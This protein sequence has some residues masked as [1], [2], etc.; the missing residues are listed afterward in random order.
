[1]LSDLALEVESLGKCY[2]VF[3]NPRDRL[4]QSLPGQKR[5]FFKAVWALEDVSFQLQ[6]GHTLGVVGRNGSGKSTLLQLICGTLSPTCGRVSVRGR[7]A[8]LLELGSGFNPD[9]SGLENVFLNG[10]LLGLK[11]SEVEDRLD[12]ILSFA[13]IGDYIHQPVKTYSSG[14]GLR[15]A[16]A[17]QAMLDPEILIVDEA[18][19]VGDERFQKKCYSHL[20]KLREQGTSVLLVTHSCPTIVQ[21]CDQAL[22]LHR[23]RARLMGTP[24]VVTTVYQR[25]SGDANA[26]WTE[27]LADLAQR[28][29]QEAQSDSAHSEPADGESESDNAAGISVGEAIYDSNLVPASRVVYPDRGARIE[30]LQILNTSEKACNLIPQGAEFEIRLRCFAEESL[31]DVRINCFLTNASGIRISGQV[32]PESSPFYGTLLSGEELDLR[33]RF[34]ARLAA[35]TYFVT[36][37]IKQRLGERHIH[38]IV[39]AAMLRILSDGQSRTVGFVDLKARPPELKRRIADQTSS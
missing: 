22:L 34:Q 26:A 11:R 24:K 28:L 33:F 19:A 9:F 20:E 3:S 1:M 14:M 15:L 21:Q 27:Q 13:D 39:D 30:D 17:V 4:L 5:Q 37:G 10:I 29:Q 16:F 23:G 38:R 35:G 18:L 31:D 25:M 32:W 7:I 36:A 6:R 2:R 8:A 12:E